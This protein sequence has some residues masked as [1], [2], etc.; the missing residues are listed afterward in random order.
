MQFLI[1]GVPVP[2]NPSKFTAKVM[3]LDNAE[4][5]T[6]TADGTLRRDRIATKRAIEVEWPPLKWDD[7]STIL[8]A[9]SGEFF[10]FTYPD[11][12]SGQIETR[13]VYAGD[14]STPIAII[15]NGVVLWDGLQVTLT[16]Q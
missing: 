5:T 6:R 3:D 9:M 13:T 14:R 2:V 15:K 1:N 10:E 8:S 16:E 12:M 11:P 4:T 7:L